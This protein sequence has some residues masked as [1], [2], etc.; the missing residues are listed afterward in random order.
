MGRGSVTE[1]ARD[2]CPVCDGKGCETCNHRGEV[3]TCSVCECPIAVDDTCILN[4][5]DGT[6]ACLHHEE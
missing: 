1:I 2:E 6:A 4:Y 5:R 3:F